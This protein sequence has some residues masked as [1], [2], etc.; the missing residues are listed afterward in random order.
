MRANLEVS[1]ANFGRIEQAAAK[2]AVSKMQLD[3]ARG[4]V[5]GLEAQ[6]K[7]AEA[8]ERNAK[9][10]FETGSDR[11]RSVREQVSQAAAKERSTRVAYE[12]R[13]EGVNPQVRQV[14]ADLELARWNLRE[15]VVYAPADGYVTNLVARPG[16]VAASLPLSPIM[17]YVDTSEKAVFLAIKQTNLRYIQPGQDAELVFGLYPG[18][19]FSAKVVTIVQGVRQGQADASGSLANP[20]PLPPSLFAVRLELGEDARDLY[21]PPGTS[22]SG[23][24]FTTRG[25]ATYIARRV[26]LRMQTYMNYIL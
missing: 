19:T 9:L 3:Q 2:E 6:L 4:E 5:E 14:L 8:A 15:T 17:T 11:V 23:A 16:F 20:L 26:M 7:Q 18:K 25:K 24:I 10:N 13:I 12:S 22:G 21:L 1:R